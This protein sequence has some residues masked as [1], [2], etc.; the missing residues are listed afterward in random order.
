MRRNDCLV[1][2]TTFVFLGAHTPKGGVCVGGETKRQ[3]L[4]SAQ[5]LGFGVQAHVLTLHPQENQESRF[6]A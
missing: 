1:T 5:A 4:P 3:K 2:F 6:L